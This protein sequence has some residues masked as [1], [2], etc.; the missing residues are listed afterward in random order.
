MIKIYNSDLLKLNRDFFTHIT[1]K[2][3]ILRG[4]V[5]LEL[6]GQMRPQGLMLWHLLLLRL[7]SSPAD[8][9]SREMAAIKHRSTDS[10][11]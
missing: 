11:I 7:L 2:Y 8:S 5:C 4:A 10:E 6:G 9:V 3:K 1:E